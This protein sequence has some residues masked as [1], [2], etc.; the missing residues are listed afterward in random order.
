[1]SLNL[2]ERSSGQHQGQLKIT[3]R[4]SS[5]ARRWLFFAAL[6]IAPSGV[7][8]PWFEAKKKTF[9][10]RFAFS[11]A[12]GVLRHPAARLDRIFNVANS[13]LG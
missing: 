8:R 9:R 5:V 1:M 3:K 6:R 13:M 4:G 10:Q 11:T 2:K 12:A 7:V